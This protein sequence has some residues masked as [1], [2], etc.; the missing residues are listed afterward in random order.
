MCEWWSQKII[1]YSDYRA[2]RLQRWPLHHS[3]FNENGRKISRSR[4]QR[5]TESC[6]LPRCRKDF[7]NICRYRIILTSWRNFSFRNTILI[8]FLTFSWKGLSRWW[9]TTTSLPRGI[10]Q[11]TLLKETSWASSSSGSMPTAR[12][13]ERSW[14][15]LSCLVVHVTAADQQY[16]TM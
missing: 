6:W 4:L 7:Y 10:S 2:V 1:R 3:S 15:Q 13:I 9:K 5:Q 12:R 14:V 11:P 8:R 16:S